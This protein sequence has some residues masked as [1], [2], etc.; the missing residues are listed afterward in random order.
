VKA[1][2]VSFVLV[3]LA[4]SNGITA[5][6]TWSEQEATVEVERDI[7][8][9][10]IKFYWHGG[11]ASMPVGVPPQHY[12]LVD[13]YPRADGGMGCIVDDP[14]LRERQ[15]KYSETYNRQMLNYL[16]KRR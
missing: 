2:F 4:A 8:R 6:K 16:L 5:P 9:H 14:A 7:A 11:Y 12:K 3:L 13:R 1:A 15:R 10:K